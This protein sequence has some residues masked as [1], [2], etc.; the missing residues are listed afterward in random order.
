MSVCQVISLFIESPLLS[1][2][3][4]F[5]KGV[6]VIFINYIY[7]QTLSKV[8]WLRVR[9]DTEKNNHLSVTFIFVPS[10]RKPGFFIM[11]MN[12]GSWP[13]PFKSQSQ[14]QLGYRVAPTFPRVEEA[15]HLHAGAWVR[16]A[17]GGAGN[18]PLLWWAAVC[19]S[20]QAPPRP[21]TEMLQQLHRLAWR[22]ERTRDFKDGG[23]TRSTR[24]KPHGFSCYTQPSVRCGDCHRPP[25]S[26]LQW[27]TVA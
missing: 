14:Q 12:A 2:H 24:L 8:F 1:L 25:N 19:R 13:L 20:D 23:W 7:L 11:N 3:G 21:L 6:D 26:I 10:C 17:E 27:C 22:D 5:C 9:P 4:I 18:Q 15:V 16:H